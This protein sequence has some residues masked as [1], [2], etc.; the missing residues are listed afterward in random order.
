MSNGMTQDFAAAIHFLRIVCFPSNVQDYAL[1]QHAGLYPSLIN[2]KYQT[3]HEQYICL[4]IPISSSLPHHLY[5]P[6]QSK[7]EAKT[8]NFSFYI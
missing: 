3:E 5:H 4:R 8:I 2:Y 1:S 7:K 6:H